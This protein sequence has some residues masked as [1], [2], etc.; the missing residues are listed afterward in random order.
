V[1]PAHI[2]FVWHGDILL[3]YAIGGFG[4]LL[5]KH[6]NLRCL[7]ILALALAL[8]A[9]LVA[10]LYPVRTEARQKARQLEDAGR[11]G[12]RSQS[13]DLRLLV[14]KGG[15][16]PKALANASPSTLYV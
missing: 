8:S 16:E 10:G 3:V 9:R 1:K 12:K 15:L 11:S 14:R 4:L 13:G 2:A 7:L 6:G 5:V